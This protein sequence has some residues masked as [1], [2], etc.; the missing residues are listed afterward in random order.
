MAPTKEH[1]KKSRE[2]RLRLRPAEGVPCRWEW[3]P[4]PWGRRKLGSNSLGRQKLDWKP[5][6]RQK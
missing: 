2:R 4:M 5:T 3:G 6:V 1:Q